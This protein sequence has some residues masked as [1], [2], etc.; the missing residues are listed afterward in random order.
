M[1][2]VFTLTAQTWTQIRK[3]LFGRV[4]RRNRILFV[5]ALLASLGIL[6]LVERLGPKWREDG[7]SWRMLNGE[8]IADTVVEGSPAELAGLLRG[9]KLI[10]IADHRVSTVE[11]V[12]LELSRS[13]ANGPDVEYRVERAGVL[14]SRHLQP[15]TLPQGDRRLSTYLSL[16][17]FFCL[18]LGTLVAMRRPGEK[19]RLHFAALCALFF[20][21]YSISGSGRLDA[22]DWGLLI[23]D[24]V[25]IALLPP[26]YLHFCLKLAKA[27][28]RERTLK[29]YGA[30]AAF[31]ALGLFGLLGAGSFPLAEVMLG[32]SDR[33]EPAYFSVFFVAGF[34][35]LW[36][37]STRARVGLE[38]RR[39]RSLALGTA[40]GIGPFIAFYAVPFALGRSGGTV[41]ELFGAIPLAVLPL[42][43]AYAIIQNRIVDI[44]FLFRRLLVS[45]IA[46]TAVFGVCLL[47]L[48]LLGDEARPDTAP[49]IVVICLV[50]LLFFPLKNR[51]QTAVD[52]LALKDRYDSRQ[53]LLRLSPELSTEL[54]RDRL[55]ERLLTGAQAALGVT[56]GA[57]FARNAGRF[58]TVRHFGLPGLPT[59]D[60]EPS[61]QRAFQGDLAESGVGPVAG[62]DDSNSDLFAHYFPLVARGEVVAVLGLGD[63]LASESID[64]D[65]AELIRSL[66][67]VSATAILNGR[68]YER[69]EEKARELTRLTDY[70]ANIVESMEAGVVVIGA[71]GRIERWNRGMERLAD[72]PRADAIGRTLA[73]ALSEDAS[74]VLAHILPGSPG[75]HRVDDADHLYKV[76]LRV[77]SGRSITVNVN[78]APFDT[79]LAAQSGAS[80]RA[81]LIFHDVTERVALERQVQQT[82]KMVAVGLLAAGVAHEVNT[83]LTGISSY[84]QLL[85]SQMD[86][87]DARIQWLDKIEKQTFR[88]AR[89]VSNLLNFARAGGSDD[90]SLDLTK[91]VGD[92]LSLVEHQLEGAK[93]RVIKELAP[94][95]PAVVGSENKIQQVLFNLILNARDAMPSGGWLTLKTSV[96]GRDVVVEVSD[97]GQGIPEADLPRIFDPFFTTKDVGQ[98]TGLGLAVSYGIVQEHGGSIQASSSRGQGTRFEVRLPIERRAALARAL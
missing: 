21:V 30:A 13:V 54:D 56:R 2:T 85:R 28:S 35:V 22:V 47:V 67:A 82:E 92:V 27:G 94:D 12:A 96:D 5:A 79:S 15:I 37:A 29:V 14:T 77:Q 80:P 53:T 46:V 25:G 71:S 93:V 23:L 65:E 60:A 33:L 66:C 26:C 90:A 41:P 91:V 52:R 64:E 75:A 50:A 3:R 6:S 20:V 31:M 87:K 38:R 86:P 4:S 48:G 68:L 73:E 19:L 59:V 72:V 36:R 88:G 55:A 57:L 10:A 98:G 11:D 62:S 43:L 51:I 18:G 76:S 84:T 1:S 70:H 42:S 49:L 40:A 17:G 89:I 78:A 95:L 24:S 61:V 69:L 45:L 34:I 58:E 44:G 81:V 63:P 7:V 39:M 74:T 16:M 83:P 97:T 9:D 32:W 8:L